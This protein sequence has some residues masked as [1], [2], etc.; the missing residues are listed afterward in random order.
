MENMFVFKNYK[1]GCCISK[2]QEEWDIGFGL[3]NHSYSVMEPINVSDAPKFIIARKI[4][5]DLYE[6][7]LTHTKFINFNG[8]NDNI[9]S[10]D[11]V[12]YNGIYAMNKKQLSEQVYQAEQLQT[13]GVYLVVSEERPSILESDNIEEI[14]EYLRENALKIISSIF[15]AN[16]KAAEMFF[17]K[18]E[19]VNKAID[20][21]LNVE[22]IKSKGRGK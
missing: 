2:K 7:I 20:S 11:T 18:Q 9:L 13:D 14:N 22:S 8:F 15:N 21:S 6:E 5:D 19:R 12:T 4:K 17:S 1:F 16:A 10:T 3:K